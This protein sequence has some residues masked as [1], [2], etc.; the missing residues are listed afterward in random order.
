MDFN[1]GATEEARREPR[2][3]VGVSFDGA[4]LNSTSGAM[5]GFLKFFNQVD[6]VDSPLMQ[7]PVLLAQ[8]KETRAFLGETLPVV[9]RG[10]VKLAAEKVNVVCVD[11]TC[12]D[13]VPD[14]DHTHKLKLD[15]VLVC[16]MSCFKFIL[17]RQKG[18]PT[19]GCFMCDAPIGTAKSMVNYQRGNLF[20]LG[21]FVGMSAAWEQEWKKHAETV[22]QPE[23]TAEE[24]EKTSASSDWAK[25]NRSFTGIYALPEVGIERYMV[26]YLHMT[27]RIIPIIFR[28]IIERV[29]SLMEL[30][31]PGVE[32]FLTGMDLIGLSHLGK[33]F[34]QKYTDAL[35]KYK[36][37]PVEACE[38]EVDE[39]GAADG[40]GSGRGR[41]RG[42][43]GGRRGGRGGG[44][45]RG[46]R[47]GRG[48]RSAINR[49]RGGRG[50]ELGG[51][52]GENSIP[53]SGSS[54]TVSVDQNNEIQAVR[55]AMRESS[56]VKFIGRDCRALEAGYPILLRC[57]NTKSADYIAALRLQAEPLLAELRDADVALAEA[58]VNEDRELGEGGGEGEEDG[59]SEATVARLLAARQAIEEKRIGILE[60]IRAVESGEAVPLNEEVFLFCVFILA[61]THP[62]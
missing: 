31:M 51:R 28:P 57:L 55:D 40:G 54:A 6:Y 45:G 47:G 29:T 18:T 36:P 15:Y 12:P 34:L 41:G 37:A 43:R 42:G 46:S 59:E 44:R 50:Q 58:Q 52:R 22:G 9:L 60:S 62:H 26:D 23:M 16:D 8:A 49:R 53:A 4:E 56:V 20:T 3:L 13:R 11:D 61:L 33:R 5:L 19:C 27:M 7:F 1:L 32:W 10:L 2:V 39:E 30:G 38:V 14:E 25:E 48:G 24:F 17:N 35:D 21:D